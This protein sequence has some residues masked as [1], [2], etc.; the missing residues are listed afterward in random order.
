MKTQLIIA[1]LSLAV[2]LG[3][4]AASLYALAD[5]SL[6]EIE[7]VLQYDSILEGGDRL[8]VVQYE[9]TY[10]ALPTETVTEGFLGRLVDDTGQLGSTQPYAGGVIPDQGFTRGLYSFYFETAPTITGPL[11]V[12]LQ[13]NPALIPTP[14]PVSTTSIVTRSGSLALSLDIIT[15]A[16]A[17][18][19]HWS[20]QEGELID[21][22]D[23]QNA[24]AVLS[25]DGD[26]YFS[27]AIPQLQEILPGLFSIAQT[28][29]TQVDEQFTEVYEDSLDD[30]WVG[31]PVENASTNLAQSLGLNVEVFETMI[32]LIFSVFVGFMALK[33]SGGQTGLGAIAAYTVLVGFALVGW[34][35]LPFIGLIA[36]VSVIMLG[37]VLFYKGAAA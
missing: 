34:G 32:A 20:T 5:P 19:T 36:F 10:G 27:N 26:E 31:T 11:Q 21:L 12:I 2:A 7:G 30:L 24:R 16:T 3:L 15:L 29:R 14:R 23:V 37:W 28:G 18:E 22:I 25:P 9:I 4:S 6:M 33:F 17:Y 13:G 8:Y 35:G 1:F